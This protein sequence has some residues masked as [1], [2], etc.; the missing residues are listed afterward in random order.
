[1]TFDRL[2]ECMHLCGDVILPEVLFVPWNFFKLNVLHDVSSQYGSEPWHYYLTASLA[3]CMNLA[4]V[5]LPGRGGWARRGDRRGVY[6]WS[7]L[8]ALGLLSA[9][10]HKE[11][12]F[13]LPVLPLLLAMAA[14]NMPR[15]NWQKTK[16]FGAIYLVLNVGAFLFL[17]C[18]HK[19]GSTNVI[20]FVFWSH[21]RTD[22]YVSKW[23]SPVKIE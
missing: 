3:P 10:N 18:V 16:A 20:R 13:L 7:S 8:T 14:S 1:M 6:A 5:F 22:N 12:R 9:L 23:I 17:S 11:Q 15:A 19:I 4:L 2:L 21:P